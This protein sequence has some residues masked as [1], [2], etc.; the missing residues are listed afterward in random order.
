MLQHAVAFTRHSK[1]SANDMN[2]KTIVQSDANAGDAIYLAMRTQII[3]AQLQPGERLVQ[4]QLAK[5]FG[6]SNIPVLEAIRR[7]ESEGLVVSHPNVGARVKVWDE[8]DIRGA[9]L[10][11]EAL[12]GVA[13]RIFVEQ[14]SPREKSRLTEL[15]RV[16]DEACLVE[17]MEELFRTDIAFHLYVAGEFNP[18]AQASALFRLVQS[19]CLLTATIRGGNFDG[20]LEINPMDSYRNHDEL[21]AALQGNDPDL[22][23]QLGK[24]HVRTVL[25]TYN[26]KIA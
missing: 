26:R 23:E 1:E 14:A 22:A 2:S 9:F 11:R 19:S 7:L 18:K 10:A 16:I 4:R 15:G 25:E 6:S 17:D 12:E 21:I 13:C 8:D 20:R 5:Q 24:K 3:T